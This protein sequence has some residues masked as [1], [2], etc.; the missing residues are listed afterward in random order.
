VKVKRP[1]TRSDE[2][3]P[4]NLLQGSIVA[5]RLQLEAVQLFLHGMP[6]KS[7]KEQA[8][9]CDMLKASAAAARSQLGSLDELL[10]FTPATILEV[11]TC[12]DMLSCSIKMSSQ[13]LKLFEKVLFQNVLRYTPAAKMLQT[14]IAASLSQ[15]ESFEQVLYTEEHE[16]QALG[17]RMCMRSEPC[18]AES[19]TLLSSFSLSDLEEHALEEDQQ[20]LKPHED[21]WSHY[22]LENHLTTDGRDSNDGQ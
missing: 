5:T 1:L 16:V 11:Q 8:I 10:H 13:Q 15:L 9:M 3:P 6:T 21:E 22:L 20:P 17:K 19:S 7:Y 12:R 4:P 2:A 14:S 18:A